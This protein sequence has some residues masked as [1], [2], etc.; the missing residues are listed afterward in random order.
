MKNL[1]RKSLII[2]DWDG[3]LMDSIGLIVTAMQVAAKKNG[4]SVS[5]EAVKIIIGLSLDKGIAQL[6]PDHP[7]L[8][9]SILQG[10]SDYYVSHCQA[11][12]LFDGVADLIKDLNQAGKTLAVATGKKRA[13]LDRV[14]DGSG[15][16]QYFATTRCTDEAHSKPDPLMLQQILAET[17]K[18]I[19]EAVFVGDSVHDIGM[20]NNLNMD[21]IAVSYGCEQADILAES[22]PTA[23]ADSVLELRQLLL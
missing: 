20:A 7:E 13:G 8:H 12:R 1:Q 11:D 23:M 17:G 10:Y 4:F 14:F 9:A 18:T 16:S 22:K 21:S 3:T 15:I 2:F 6:F 5:D 19:A